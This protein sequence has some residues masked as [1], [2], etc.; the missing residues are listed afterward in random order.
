MHIHNN[1]VLHYLHNIMTV[2]LVI[3]SKARAFKAKAKSSR[4]RINIPEYK[5]RNFCYVEN[6]AVIYLLNWWSWCDVDTDW[7]EM[8]GIKPRWD[9]QIHLLDELLANVKNSSMSYESEGIIRFYRL[10]RLDQLYYRFVP[11]IM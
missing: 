9:N 10:S 1:S 3:Y 8:E 2:G 4:P 6:A 5:P 11:I 7:K